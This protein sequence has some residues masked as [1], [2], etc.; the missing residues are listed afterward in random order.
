MP[1]GWE[2]EAVACRKMWLPKAAVGKAAGGDE[3]SHEVVG[4][5]AKRDHGR[6]IVGD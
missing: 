5:A 2:C 3:G 6:E 4:A 1:T